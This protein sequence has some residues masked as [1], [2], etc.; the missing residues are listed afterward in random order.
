MQVTQ[1][2]F[3]AGREIDATT[4]LIYKGFKQST[5]LVSGPSTSG[6]HFAL[7]AFGIAPGLPKNA[8]SSKN[9]PFEAF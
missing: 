2:G 4:S 5:Y 8:N 7:T 1:I 6:P 3:G 9:R